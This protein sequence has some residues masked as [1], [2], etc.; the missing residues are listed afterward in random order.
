MLL[1]YS[2]T[3]LYKT[4]HEI[5]AKL[6]NAP[7]ESGGIIGNKSGTVCR[8]HFDNGRQGLNFY[9]P[10]IMILNPI[11]SQWFQQH[12]SFSGI[13]HSHPNGLTTLSRGDITYAIDI[14]RMNQLSSILFPIVTQVQDGSFKLFAYRI[15]SIGTVEEEKIN[16]IL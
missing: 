6:S 1:E 16:I 9:K 4:Y 14:L 3:I 13:V 15:N 12:I 11:L 2:M 7:I 10:N 5:V 8:F